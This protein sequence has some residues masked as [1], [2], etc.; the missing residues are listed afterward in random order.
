MEVVHALHPS[1]E[2]LKILF[3]AGSL[4]NFR[5]NQV[6]G[7]RYVPVYQ[8]LNRDSLRRGL[9]PEGLNPDGSVDEDHSWLRR[10]SSSSCSSN[11]LQLS[12]SFIVPRSSPNSFSF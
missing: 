6:G 12:S 7:S 11:S 3:R 10:I 2:F 4:K 9:P 8:G 1:S 5:D